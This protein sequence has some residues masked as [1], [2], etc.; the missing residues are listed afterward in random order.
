M[1]GGSIGEESE[2]AG[3]SPRAQNTK[4]GEEQMQ[5][6]RIDIYD[7]FGPDRSWPDIKYDGVERVAKIRVY[8]DSLEEITN[9]TE[10]I[11]VALGI[12]EKNS[13]IYVNIVSETIKYTILRG[14]P[15]DG[16]ETFPLV[17]KMR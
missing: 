14:Y 17:W 4:G 10:R 8:S 16:T 15:K 12:E 7:S 9:A 11:I 1:S 5:T 6:F 13:L 3:P 2:Y